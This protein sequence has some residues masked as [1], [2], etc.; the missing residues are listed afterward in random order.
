MQM[1]RFSKFRMC[2]VIW[3]FS[4]IHVASAAGAECGGQVTFNGSGVPGAVVT[5]SLGRQKQATI[6]DAQG[7]YM[8]SELP[9]GVWNMRIE[10]QAFAPLQREVAVGPGA[11]VEEWE[12][13]LLTIDRI[14]GLR[15]PLP[16]P[17]RQPQPQHQP[18]L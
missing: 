18:S 13:Q 6:T 11:A 7:R 14:K 4:L 1:L 15:G 12:L 8:F 10:M 17:H 16:P 2:I 3:L 5:A 9:D